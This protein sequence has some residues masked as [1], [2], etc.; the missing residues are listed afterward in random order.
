M[1]N[2]WLQLLF[3]LVQ[4]FFIYFFTKAILRRI[5]IY[6]SSGFKN[7]KVVYWLVSLIYFPGTFLHETA[8]LTVATLLLLRIKEIQLWPQITAENTLKLGHVLYE[9]R[10]AVKGILVGIAPFLMGI[11]FFWA[12]VYFKLFPNQRMGMNILF[13]YL[14]FTVS[15]TMFS[16]KQDLV[17]ILYLV[18]LAIIGVGAIYVFDFSTVSAQ[19]LQTINNY[20]LIPLILNFCLWIFTIW[21]NK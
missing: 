20:L 15:S 4:V 8:H 1:D 5:F 9:K 3:F 21:L 16:S 2:I 10:G 6:L 14:I 18:P 12:L 17:D 7:K 13:G 19:L 11:I